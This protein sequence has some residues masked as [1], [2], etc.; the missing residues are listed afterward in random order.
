MYLEGSCHCRK[1]SFSC[2]SKSPFPFNRCYCS[3]CRKLNGGGGYAVNIMADSQS[4]KIEGKDA[5]KVYR[6]AT[7]DRKI[8]DQDGLGY[9]RRS[10]CGECGS[11]LWNYNEN[12]SQWIYPFASAI[13]TTLPLPTEFRHIMVKYREN[14]IDIPDDEMKFDLY[15][16]EGIEGWHKKRN[17]WDKE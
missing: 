3:I 8:F 11:M 14:W 7:N 15:P 17:L 2:V 5:I 1:V 16:D 12:H 10:F 4:L 13:D 6:S 9:S